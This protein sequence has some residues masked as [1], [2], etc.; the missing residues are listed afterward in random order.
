MSISLKS[1]K[2][3]IEDKEAVQVLDRFVERTL[4]AYLAASRSE[5]VSPELDDAIVVAAVLTQLR[6][7]PEV[8]SFLGLKRIPRGQKFSTDALLRSSGA[9]NHLLDM[10]AQYQAGNLSRQD[11]L[12]QLEILALD[13]FGE[14]P[15]DDTTLERLLSELVDEHNAI[16]EGCRLVLESFGGNMSAAEEWARRTVENNR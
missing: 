9:K 11:A 8:R 6:K 4:Q 15:K 16:E 2:A 13:F 12:D 1:L 7:L 5:T 14:S 3:L 10:A